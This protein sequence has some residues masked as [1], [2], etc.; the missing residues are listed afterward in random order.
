MLTNDVISF[1]QLG[2]AL[3]TYSFKCFCPASI[4]CISKSN[5]VFN[6]VM[7]DLLIF[8]PYNQISKFIDICKKN[9][10]V[11]NGNSF[12]PNLQNFP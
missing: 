3:Q 6:L 9:L 4:C 11:W 1:E 5:S 2:P 10:L 7:S 8:Q 12:W